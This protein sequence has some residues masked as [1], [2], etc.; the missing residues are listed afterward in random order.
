[1]L[2]VVETSSS[3]D[4]VTLT[5]PSPVPLGTIAVFTCGGTGFGIVWD[6]ANATNSSFIGLVGDGL[7]DTIFR[8][9][10]LSVLAIG[11]N[12]NTAV[13]CIIVRTIGGNLQRTETLTIY[14]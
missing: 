7:P 10:R 9:S 11:E 1:M 8:T 6:T 5:N 12:N 14:G 4:D 2:L 3:S 13:T